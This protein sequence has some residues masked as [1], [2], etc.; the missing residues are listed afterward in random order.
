MEVSA[1]PSP[2]MSGRRF[3]SWL[4]AGTFVSLGV[5][6]LML[7]LHAATG[8]DSLI[9]PSQVI[10]AA[11]GVL[12]V[13]SILGGIVYGW[14]AY[15]QHRRAIVFIVALT[16]VVLSAHAYIIGN[17][18]ASDPP[19][20]LSGAVG[21]HIVS[22]DK[23]NFG[24]PQVTITSTLTGNQLSVTF[25]ATGS[26][27]SNGGGKAIVLPQLVAPSQVSGTGFGSG[28]TL[29][30]P[31]EPGGQVTGTWTVSGQ[32]T[33]I[34]VTYQ[35]LNCYKTTSP[36]EYGCIM[37]EIFYVPWGMAIFTGQTCSTGLNAP[38]DCHLEH[39]WLGP[40]LMAAGMAVL[41]EFN[42]AGW[43]L[44]PVLLGTFS[45]P[46]LFGIAWKVSG[47]KKVAYLSALLLAADI[48][49]FSQSSAAV[50]DIPEIFFALAGFFAYFAG[51]RFWK[52]DKYVTAGVLL[53]L[54]GLAKETAIFLAPALVTYILLFDEG[55]LRRRSFAVL[56]VA[57]VVGLVFFTGLEA[58][59]S[60]LVS[61]ALP[62]SSACAVN[63][64]NFVQNI[65]YILC[66][67]SSLNAGCPWA[68]GWTNSPGSYITPFSWVTYYNPVA[69]LKTDVIVSTGCSNGVCTGSYT[70]PSVA[71][72]GVTNFLETWTIYVWIP[73]VAYALYTQFRRK[74]QA[75]EEPYFTS[76]GVTPSGLSG[77]MKLGAFALILFVWSYVP[78]LFLFFAGRVTYP[79]YFLPAVPAVALGCTYWLT[80]S[81]FPRWLMVFYVVMAFGFFFIYFPEKGF[82]PDWLRVL[83]GH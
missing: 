66:Y 68:C 13:A 12:A 31:L 60:V 59:D 78:Y 46:L 53:G 58:Y 2:R 71:Y 83:I 10:A 47:S 42:S 11:L 45:I 18:P 67:G 1:T 63:G 26:A 17:P 75:A 21:S 33:D 65:G 55:G 44:F 40:G 28:A 54:A 74:N 49:F 39:P 9:F 80:R 64:A 7:Y 32:A 56:K 24:N 19:T 27:E 3:L 25:A 57:L 62:G 36:S 41:G 34:K 70:Y 23:D 4:A 20:A 5:L 50:L 29:A 37:D 43:R 38:T 22:P 14:R 30:S 16:L 15:P 48:M 81:W 73:L 52:F 35:E 72:Y 8:S 77:D 6:L 51:L 79:F 69:Y 61:P 82:L 76:L